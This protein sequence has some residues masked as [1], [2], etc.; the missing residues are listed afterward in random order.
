MASPSVCLDLQ[1]QLTALRGVPAPRRSPAWGRAPFQRRGVPGSWR[2]RAHPAASA[3]PQPLASLSAHPRPHHAPSARPSAADL[4]VEL[5]L[6]AT[7]A[8]SP[9][10]RDLTPCGCR[11]RPGAGE[12][13]W[14]AAWPLP[15]PA[16]GGS[17]PWERGD[18]LGARE[19]RPWGHAQPRE[20][21][22]EGPRPL[23]RR[24]SPGLGCVPG[25]PP[26]RAPPSPGT[27][28]QALP[29]SPGEG[30]VRGRSLVRGQGWW[31]SLTPDRPLSCQFRPQVP[32]MRLFF[33]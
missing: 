19:R 9:R 14:T 5:R 33:Q 20:G 25:S 13:R 29:A 16:E 3:Q 2:P 7:L 23:G 28:R 10:A 17:G 32:E 30:G 15:P 12:G 6:A 1:M 21:A 26:P 4:Y 24:G 27:G 8:S 11:P 22:R 18:V 31:V